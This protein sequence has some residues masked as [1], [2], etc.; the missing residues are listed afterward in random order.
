LP[1]WSSQMPP[2][3][4]LRDESTWIIGPAGGRLYGW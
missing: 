2:A 1:R 3:D 4:G